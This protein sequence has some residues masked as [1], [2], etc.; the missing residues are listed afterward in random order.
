[1][2]ERPMR[3]IHQSDDAVV[4]AHRHL[5]CE[6]HHP[7]ALAEFRQLG[8][9][10]D[11]VAALRAKIAIGKNSIM[12]LSMSDSNALAYLLTRRVKVPLKCEMKN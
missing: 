11:R 2:H 12:M 5:G 7:V 9:R 10:R 4:Q 3:R 6:M 8:R 1:M